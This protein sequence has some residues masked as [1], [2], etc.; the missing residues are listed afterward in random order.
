M[1][2]FLCVV[3]WFVR[4][5]IVLKGRNVS[6]CQITSFKNICMCARTMLWYVNWLWIYMIICFLLDMH[7]MQ[8]LVSV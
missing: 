8:I 5:F 2:V 1:K 4:W 3:L 6:S 7:G